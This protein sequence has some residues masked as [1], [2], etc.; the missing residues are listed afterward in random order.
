MARLLV[1]DTAKQCWLLIVWAVLHRQHIITAQCKHTGRLNAAWPAAHA[2]KA[3]CL[4]L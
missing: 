3:S 4:Q 1:A 2:V